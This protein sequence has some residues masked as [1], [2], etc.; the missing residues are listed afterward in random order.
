[1]PQNPRLPW[2]WGDFSAPRQGLGLSWGRRW[3]GYQ[4]GGCCCWS[5]GV[6]GKRGARWASAF[7]SG[8]VAL[9][10]LNQSPQLPRASS[11]LPVP[12][13]WERDP[14]WP[15]QTG[16]LLL[17]CPACCH[18]V[19]P[20]LIPPGGG[21]FGDLLLRTTKRLKSTHLGCDRG[22]VIRTA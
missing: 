2:L 7:H 9:P 3:S 20:P 5:M 4:S 14:A 21:S 13:P 1:M 22:V 19:P 17:Q 10:A 18:P 15:P 6:R 11:P 16:H 12:A 8:I